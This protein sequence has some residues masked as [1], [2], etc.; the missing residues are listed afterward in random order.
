MIS[1]LTNPNDSQYPSQQPRNQSSEVRQDYA[2]R[3]RDPIGAT[4]TPDQTTH[5]QMSAK[6][7]FGLV[8]FLATITHENPD[9]SGLAR[10]HDLTSLGLN[11]NSSELVLPWSAIF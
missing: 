3:P 2:N 5:S 7:E 1:L 11:L 9:V 4:H 10:G 6:D 8:G